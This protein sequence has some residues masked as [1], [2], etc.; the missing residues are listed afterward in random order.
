MRP[1]DE[2]LSVEIES[3]RD[4]AGTDGALSGAVPCIAD[5]GPLSSDSS[6][7]KSETALAKLFADLL[8]SDPSDLAYTIGIALRPSQAG[9][10]LVKNANQWSKDDVKKLEEA[11]RGALPDATGHD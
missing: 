8:M 2:A 3:A 5:E 6:V 9:G 1:E 11:V 4:K 10:Y 7:I